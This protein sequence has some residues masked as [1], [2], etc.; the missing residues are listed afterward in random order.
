MVTEGLIAMPDVEVIKYV[1]QEAEK[2]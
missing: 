2:G 1:H